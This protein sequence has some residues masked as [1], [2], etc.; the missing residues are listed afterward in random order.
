MIGN[1]VICSVYRV[2]IESNPTDW[3]WKWLIP[4]ITFLLLSIFFSFLKIHLFALNTLNWLGKEEC[5][6]WFWTKFKIHSAIY[7]MN[8]TKFWCHFV[9]I[10][11]SRQ[12]H[13]IWIEGSAICNKRNFQYYRQILWRAVWSKAEICINHHNNNLM[14]MMMIDYANIQNN[15][16]LKFFLIFK[17]F[18]WQCILKQRKRLGFVLCKSS[19]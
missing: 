11:C 10:S 15:L 8:G 5:R 13:E 1:Y 9:L 17:T 2:V 6:K 14:I 18:F 19:K 3:K 7:T 12:L 16:L 4:T